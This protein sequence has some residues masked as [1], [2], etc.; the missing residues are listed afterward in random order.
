MV[1]GYASLT[2][3]TKP[4][5]FKEAKDMKK[6]LVL[7]VLVF[8]LGCV[9][10]AAVIPPQGPGQIGYSSVVLCDSLSLR[11][12]PNFSSSTLQTLH[13]GDRIIVM[14]TQ[15]GW[16]HC[17]LGDSEDSPAGYVNEDFIAID[18]A[19]YR[20]EGDTLVCAWNDTAAPK[21][22]LLDE[23]TTLPILRDDGDWIIVSL[24]GATG[25]INNPVRSSAASSNATASGSGSG[26]GSSS[27][28]GSGSGGGSITVY[29][30][31]GDAYTL[32]EG[33][34]GRW[35]DRS[36]T[37]YIRVSDTDFQ[38]YEGTKRLSTNYPSQDYDDY[39]YDEEIEEDFYSQPSL[40]AYDE[41]GNAYTI[42]MGS[43]G[44][45]REEDG[46][47]YVRVSDTEFQVKDGNK[48]LTI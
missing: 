20:T 18:P 11:S 13:Y 27:G 36:G 1:R 8:M 47:T 42:Y 14:D 5:F 24:R 15:D 38:V 4:G 41:F 44:Y 25:W 45:W 3:T 12:A 34:D 22:A 29:D 7:S 19:W 9:C 31:Y 6:I 2:I 26:S 33:T 16:A 46:T 39:D 32:Y 35:R 10:H 40:T 21:V 23:G 28:S 17:V 48:R 43:D 37:E 30:E